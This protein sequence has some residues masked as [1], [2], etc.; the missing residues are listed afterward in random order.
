MKKNKKMQQSTNKMNKNNNISNRNQNQVNSKS[1]RCNEVSNS[2]HD[3][4]GFDD[5]SHEDSRSFELDEDN[6]H[7]F[8]LK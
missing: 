6:G 7:S 3:S 2:E 5:D 8:E 1:K 4:I